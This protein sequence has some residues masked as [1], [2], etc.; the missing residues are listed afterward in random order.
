MN[1]EKIVIIGAGISGLYLAFLLQEKYDITIL[2]ARDRIGGRIYS[3]DGHD[4]GPSWVWQ[5]HKNILELIE[6]FDLQLFLQYENGYALYDTQNTVEKFMPQQNIPSARM[7]GTLTKLIDT[8]Y[9]QLKDVTIVLNSE[10]VSIQEQENILLKTK[11]QEYTS[12]YAISTLPPRIVQN[13][14]FIPP[15]PIQVE[16]KMRNTQTWMGN[17]AKCVIEFKTSFW[18][19]KGLSGFVFSNI[20]PLAEI[21]DA[22]TRT[23]NALFGFLR[24]KVDTDNYKKEL[25]EQLQR[26]FSIEESEILAIH[27]VDW[28]REKYTSTK[29]DFNTMATHPNYGIDTTSYSDKI[30]FSSTEFSFKEGGYIEGAIINAQTIAKRLL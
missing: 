10:V 22:T 11:N 23:K 12:N 21:H 28:K 29:E 17:S 8:L 16:E 7:D 14:N 27:L 18:R 6:K 24:L 19:E 1:K 5:H 9:N 3:I 26:V 15:L 13:L 25:L 2:E 30:L 4:M 20:G